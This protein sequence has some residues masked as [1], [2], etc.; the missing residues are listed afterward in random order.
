MS[1]S[2]RTLHPGSPQEGVHTSCNV[3]TELRLWSPHSCP[4]GGNQ[5]AKCSLDSTPCPVSFAWGQPP[6]SPSLRKKVGPGISETG[7][8]PEGPGQAEQPE[9]DSLLTSGGEEEGEWWE[10]LR[11]SLAGRNVFRA[12]VKPKA[13]PAAGSAARTVSTRA[14]GH[15]A[16]SVN[17][18]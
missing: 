10:H 1:P 5:G 17:T 16:G 12:E 6:R 3:D 14:G 4:G 2:L 15:P 18:C 11:S 13:G 9:R 8:S 7:I